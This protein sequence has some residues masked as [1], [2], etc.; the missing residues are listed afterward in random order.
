MLIG[1]NIDLWTHPLV[2]KA[3]S[4]FGKPIVWEEDQNHLAIVLVK[5][6]V[7]GLGTI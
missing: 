1:L 6:R 3:I 5:A 4:Q 7:S 2:D